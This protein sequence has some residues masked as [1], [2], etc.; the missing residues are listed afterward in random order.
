ME[1]EDLDLNLLVVFNQ[2][3]IE[4]KVSQV[5]E[6]LGLGQPAVSNAL[7]R[8]RKLFGDE[9]F[10]RTSNGM[11][12]TPFAAQLAGSITAALGMIHGAIN[13]KASFEPASSTRRFS[14]GMTDIGEIYFL[15]RL[16]K[17]IARIAPSVTVSTVRNTSV[18]LKDD[19]EAGRIDLAIG[20]LPQLDR[21]FFRRRLFMQKYVCMF[22]KGHRLD[23]GKISAADFFA[24]DHV[25]IVSEGT[26]HGKVDEIL[27]SSVAKR[28][29]SLTVPHFVAVGHILQSTDMVATVPERLAYSMVKPF[30]LKYVPHPVKLPQIAINLFWHARYQKDPA[31]Q[32]LRTLVFDLHSG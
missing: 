4:R 3:L 7:A 8:M 9:L 23:K 17:E 10:L 25:A 13:L 16:M 27:D 18:R 20:L 30:D 6:N 1:L 12:P 19:M 11:E 5:A 2:L 14:I 26:G 28:K 32:W 24:A 22:C 31:N 15:P 21:G 29:I